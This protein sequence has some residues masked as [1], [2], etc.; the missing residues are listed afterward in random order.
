MDGLKLAF[1]LADVEAEKCK[2]RKDRIETMG[3]GRD[4]RRRKAR[5][6]KS[7]GRAAQPLIGDPPIADDPDAVVYASSKLKPRPQSGAIAIAEPEEEN[8]VTI[9][10]RRIS[11]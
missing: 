10:P 5:K 6:H 11:K 9:Y 4:K 2:G 1:D 7:P 3:K 8:A